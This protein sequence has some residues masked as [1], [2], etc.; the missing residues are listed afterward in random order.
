M[1]S[2]GRSASK[3]FGGSGM[4]PAPIML[5]SARLMGYPNPPGAP[6]ISSSSLR[7][8]GKGIRV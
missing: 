3:L 8:R 7:K 2:V 6:S 5:P 4:L 1:L